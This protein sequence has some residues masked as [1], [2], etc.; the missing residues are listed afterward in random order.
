MPLVV[1]IA[2]LHL[3]AASRPK[4]TAA[5]GRNVSPEYSHERLRWLATHEGGH[6]IA[7]WRCPFVGNVQNVSVKPASGSGPVL[8]TGVTNHDWLVERGTPEH[9]WWDM[10]ISLAGLAAE[11]ATYGSIV[12]L[13]PR[14]DIDD[15]LLSVRTLCKTRGCFTGYAPP[16]PLD[17]PCTAAESAA[18]G[19]AWKKATEILAAHRA[20]HAILTEM[21]IAERTLSSA[22]LTAILGPRVRN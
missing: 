11:V 19:H 18:L 8:W 16:I 20:E 17:V 6:T 22:N 10:I 1:L 15:A 4:P 21:L 3:L 12:T 9:L 7:A 14:K 5:V 13:P 2:A